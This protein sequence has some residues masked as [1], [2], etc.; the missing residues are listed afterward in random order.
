MKKI[1]VLTEEQRNKVKELC[2]SGETQTYSLI[3][4]IPELLGKDFFC[5][6]DFINNKLYVIS[7]RYYTE[8]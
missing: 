3:T 2:I 4:V 6:Q 5:E 7:V 8:E 1:I